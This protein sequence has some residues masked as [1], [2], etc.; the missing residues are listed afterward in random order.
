MPPHLDGNTSRTMYLLNSKSKM[1]S[2]FMSPYFTMFIVLLSSTFSI[3]LLAED[4][5]KKHLFILSGQSN[6]HGMKVKD[7]FGPAIEKEFGK[8]SIVIVK[9]A[10]GGTAIKQWAYSRKR[11]THGPAYHGLMSKVKEATTN[12]KF[13]SVTFIWMQG[14]SDALQK[15]SKQYYK[16][17]L[18]SIMTQIKKDLSLEKF[19]FVL[20]RISDHQLDNPYWTGIREALVEI[21]DSDKGFLSVVLTYSSCGH[22]GYL[23]LVHRAKSNIMS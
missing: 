18:K 1:E 8:D 12:L 7:S 17:S 4:S 3:N 19:Y 9:T 14:E 10:H 2:D 21:A 6:M 23:T 11:N 22:F 15:K 20:G 5:N 16:S 13:D